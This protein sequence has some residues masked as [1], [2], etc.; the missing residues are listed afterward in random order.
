MRT[1]DWMQT[2]GGRAY[3]PLDPRADEVDI[4]DI[5]HALAHQ[6]RYA[7]HC[8]RFYSVAEHS[9]LVSLVVPRADAMHALLHDAPEA[10]CVDVP[11]AVKRALG[12]GYADIEER[13]WRA[14]ADR[15]SLSREM[16]VSV[17]LADNEVLLAEKAALMGASP[18]PWDVPGEPA[19]VRVRGLWP[20]EARAL[21][22]RRFAELT[23]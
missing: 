8:S 15:F 18:M 4:E 6:C 10:Y 7:G 1:G 11:R 5:A 12:V 3:W 19:D 9:V 17:K 21:F 2:A 14:I 13:N 22:L 23:T 20:I 16:P